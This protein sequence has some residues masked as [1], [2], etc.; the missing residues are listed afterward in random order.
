MCLSAQYFCKYLLYVPIGDELSEQA[1][2]SSE[3]NRHEERRDQFALQYQTTSGSS[4]FLQGSIRR[5]PYWH[6]NNS[7]SSSSTT[8]KLLH[9]VTIF[10]NISQE[11]ETTGTTPAACDT[12]NSAAEL[13]HPLL[14]PVTTSEKLH[15]TKRNPG[16]YIYIFGDALF[17]HI[18]YY[19]FLKELQSYI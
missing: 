1:H 4:S 7:S 18:L 5:C 8:Y 17:T 13:T 10:R 14:P 19:K 9:T 15:C 2:V 6:N 11:A 16:I 12:P 3:R